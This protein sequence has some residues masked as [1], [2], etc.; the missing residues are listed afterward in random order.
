MVPVQLGAVVQEA[1][2]DLLSR[3][4]ERNPQPTGVQLQDI[5][6]KARK[7]TCPRCAVLG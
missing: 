6:K 1:R 2:L 4:F 5:A 3:E 7:P